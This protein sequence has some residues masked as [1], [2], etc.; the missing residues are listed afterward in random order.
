MSLVLDYVNWLFLFQFIHN[1]YLG[2]ISLTLFLSLSKACLEAKYKMIWYRPVFKNYLFENLPLF[3][4]VHNFR[5]YVG[6]K[7]IQYWVFF[8]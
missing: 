1:S 2:K 4:E 7:I 3:C 8:L 6:E 5:D